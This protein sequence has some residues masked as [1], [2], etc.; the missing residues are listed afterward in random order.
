ELSKIA[1]VEIKDLSINNLLL[2]GM[3]G[4]GKTTIGKILAK[5]LS[6]N[7]I[8][9]DEFIEE[10]QGSRIRDIVEKNG[11]EFFRKLET[12][13]CRELSQLKN[14]VIASGGGAILKEEN[15]AQSDENTLNLLFVANPSLL[16]ER[17]S[18]DHNRYELTEQPT[19]LG[20]LGEVWK[21][22]KEKYFMNA[23]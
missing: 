22:R 17:I 12:Q 14:T 1:E 7:F 2:T 23:D 13:A 11:W 16:S 18:G 19:L 6:M 15:M 4:S 10:K 5:K 3:R 21:K 8:D 20:E 9:M